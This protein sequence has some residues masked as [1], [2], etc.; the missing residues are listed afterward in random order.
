MVNIT[1]LD[2]KKE[3]PKSKTK[4]KTRR[5]YTDWKGKYKILKQK[6]DELEQKFTIKNT[7]LREAQGILM[8]YQDKIKK[9]RKLIKDAIIDK[10]KAF[11]RNINAYCKRH[12]IKEEVIA[13]LPIEKQPKN[14]REKQEYKRILEEMTE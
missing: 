10:M 13:E 5:S 12:G 4:S 2:S 11:Q 7:Q 3:K 1:F 9:D 14:Y 8:E 6:Y